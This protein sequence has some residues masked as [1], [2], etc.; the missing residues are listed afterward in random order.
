MRKVF[1]LILICFW[2]LHVFIPICCYLIFGFVPIYSNVN[3]VGLLVKVTLLETITIFGTSCLLC[4]LPDKKVTIDP[5]YYNL[6]T[7]FYFSS[8]YA[9]VY[10]YF[11]GGFLGLLAGS[12]N[13]TILSYIGLFFSL[14]VVLAM[15]SFYQKK[16]YN[17][18]L[19]LLFFIFIKTF[20][21]S[22]SAIMVIIFILF[23]FMLFNNYKK[24][25]TKL[26]VIILLGL[27]LAPTFYVFATMQRGTKFGDI[28]L[29]KG[30]IGRLST[31]EIAMLP[32][33]CKDNDSPK[34][35]LNVFYEKYNI[36]NQAKLAIDSVYPGTLFEY[37]VDPN[38]YYLV[39]FLE[40]SKE[41][42][43]ANYQSMNITLPTYFYMYYGF[44]ISIILSILVFTGYYLV[45]YY[46]SPR[47]IY[48]FI[49]LIV[50]LYPFLYFFDFV[51]WFRQLYATMLT[52][53]M[54]N[55]FAFVRKAVVK[56]YK[57]S[58]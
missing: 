49:G 38:R 55:I 45:W 48:I 1:I 52:V 30:V 47:N 34:C 43:R 23:P 21:G 20:T 42:V 19:L 32:V 25:K 14:H 37:D 27:F 31:L 17:I 58:G 44:Y 8:L 41:Y 51:M 16:R 11:G 29:V 39:A 3:D 33:F 36:V 53:L 54:V 13:G 50:T 2:F 15:L 26:Y 46:F 35:N 24:Y 12:L 10:Y 22:R 5:K 28:N 4:F 7:L 18:L 9:V 6:T 56:S 57:C 40:H